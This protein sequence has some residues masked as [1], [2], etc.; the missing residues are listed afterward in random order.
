MPVRARV[1]LARSSLTSQPAR[2]THADSQQRGQSFAVKTHKHKHIT[3]HSTHKRKGHTYN[4]RYCSV[5]SCMMALCVVCVFFACFCCCFLSL[6][7]VS[8]PTGGDDTYGQVSKTPK[9]GTYKAIYSGQADH[10]CAIDWNDKLAACWGNNGNGQS[11]VPAIYQSSTFLSVS[12]GGTFTCGILI[13]GNK[14]VWSV[15]IVVH[16]MLFS[17]YTQ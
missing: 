2:I 5:I 13:T 9:T 1:L 6:C 15:E 14:L 3:Q 8:I 12:T 11:N 17:T 4:N 10:T 7:C 16:L